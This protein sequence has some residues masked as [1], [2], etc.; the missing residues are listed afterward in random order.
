LRC[1]PEEE[2]SEDATELQTLNPLQKET[3]KD[4]KISQDFSSEQQSEV[5]TLLKEYQ[6]ILLMFLVSLHWKNTVSILPLQSQS[7]EKHILYHMQ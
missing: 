5:R 7:G 6:D 2:T 3:V 4:V 1:H